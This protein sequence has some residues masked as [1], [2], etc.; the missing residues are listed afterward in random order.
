MVETLDTAVGELIEQFENDLREKKIAQKE[1]LYDSENVRK[2]HIDRYDWEDLSMDVFINEYAKKKR[3]VIIQNLPMMHILRVSIVPAPN[4]HRSCEPAFSR[5][6]F[7]HVRS[8]H[9]FKL[10]PNLP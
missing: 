6:S 3:P 9:R 4:E 8:G 2:V 1:E 7:E 10:L 5:P